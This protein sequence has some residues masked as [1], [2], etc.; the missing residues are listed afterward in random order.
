LFLL[1]RDSEP[2]V[3]IEMLNRYKGNVLHCDLAGTVCETLAAALAP[4]PP[5]FAS[6]AEL[7]EL[8]EKA[9]AQRMLEDLESRE[10]EERERIG[11]IER[12][13]KQ[14]LGSAQLRAIMAAVN[15]AA[16]NGKME[17]LAFQFPSDLCTDRGRAV[18]NDEPTWPD[19]LTGQPRQFYELW[20]DHLRPKGYRLQAHVLDYPGGMPGNI[21]FTLSWS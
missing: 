14:P 11:Q 10:K 1:V 12:L 16:R 13:R 19:S 5:R 18:N 7:R 15:D 20:R 17:V 9:V 21:G 3:L 4:P 2:R 6:A 8:A